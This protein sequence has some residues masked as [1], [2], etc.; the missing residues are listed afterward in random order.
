MQKVEKSLSTLCTTRFS[1]VSQEMGLVN[2]VRRGNKVN[3]ISR[4]FYIVHILL[5]PFKM[6]FLVENSIFFWQAE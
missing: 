2:S 6:T 1:D 5:L 3:T 4:L